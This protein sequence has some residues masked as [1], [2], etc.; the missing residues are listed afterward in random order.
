VLLLGIFVSRGSVRTFLFF[1]LFV[2]PARSGLL[3]YCDAGPRME[4]SRAILLDGARI[5]YNLH[6]VYGEGESDY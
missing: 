4:G 5:I 3:F 6:C 2:I 1:F